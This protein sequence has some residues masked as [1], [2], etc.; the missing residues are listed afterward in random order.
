MCLMKIVKLRFSKEYYNLTLGF[1]KTTKIE[2]IEFYGSNKTKMSESDEQGALYIVVIVAEMV[3]GV[4]IPAPKE[5]KEQLWAHGVTFEKAEIFGNTTVTVNYTCKS[6]NKFFGEEAVS[7]QFNSSDKNW[8]TLLD[9]LLK[10][11]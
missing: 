11:L 4:A 1:L 10:H 6:D 3:R 5:L 2:I 7:F 8:P 9:T